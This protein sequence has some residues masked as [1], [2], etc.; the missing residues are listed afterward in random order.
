MSDKQIER[1]AQ[2]RGLQNVDEF[3]AEVRRHGAWTFARRPLDLVALMDTW[4]QSNSLGTRA[5]QHETNVTTKLRDNPDRPGNDVLSEAKARYG[6]ECLALALSLTRNRS[7]RSPEQALDADRS[8][9]VLDP[10]GILPDWPAAERQAL[11]RLALFDPATHGRV[12]FHH[13]STEEYLAAR[14]LRSLLKKGMST[15]AMLRLLFATNYGVEVVFPSM[16]AIAAWL[17]LWNDAVRMVWLKGLFRFDPARGARLLADEFEGNSDPAIR[18]RVI[19]AFAFVF[20]D[21]P[22]DFRVSDRVQHACL[23]GRLVRLAHAFVRPADDQVHEEVYSPDTRDHA[24]RARSTLF[25]WLCNTPGPEARLALLELAE[26]N[27]FADLRDRVRLIARQRAAIDAEF[28]PFD[29]N[30]VL[31][32]GERYEVPPNDGNGLFAIMM[33]RLSD[34]DHDL[35]HGDFSDRRTVRRID[36]EREMQRTLSWRIEERA[37]GAYRVIREDE[38]ADA[39]QPDIRLATVGGIDRKVVL[40][41]KIA[42]KGWSF[43]D[44]EDAL[45]KQLVGQY[46][47]HANCHGGCLLLTHHGRKKYWMHPETKKRLTFS[48]VVG[49]LREKARALEQEH[50]HRICVEVFGLDLTDSAPASG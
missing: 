27:E 9:G 38:V 8:D 45:R 28:T 31:A 18:K 32:L 15:K 5:Q 35:A 50:K 33:D 36:D 3:L 23:L 43:V 16:R 49:I 39:K 48:E 26:R 24:E 17:A 11:L 41:V 46:L 42:D 44:L 47:R 40:E 34:L 19:E 12:R 21:D 29:A 37:K 4:K 13:R 30:A 6:A 25:Q 14:R 2:Q 22:I 1:F 10:D 7:I 20:G